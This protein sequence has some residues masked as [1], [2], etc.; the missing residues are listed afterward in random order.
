MSDVDR[1]DDFAG[2][3][4]TMY[5]PTVHDIGMQCD[6]DVVAPNNDDKGMMP[7][8]LENKRV[9]AVL[10][11]VVA[12]DVP[13]LHTDSGFDEEM[14]QQLEFQPGAARRVETDASKTAPTAT[15][16]HQVDPKSAGPVS[17]AAE[18]AVSSGACCEYT[19]KLSLSTPAT[20]AL[21]SD[22]ATSPE[23]ALTPAPLPYGH[24]NGDETTS[25]HSSN[26]TIQPVELETAAEHKRT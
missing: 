10:D 20:P 7:H 23:L 4:R 8:P 2:R 12:R 1:H 24:T 15:P 16:A 21:A 5:G 14:V 6:T 17:L 19:H 3:G 18:N 11:E 25:K 26:V 22:P 9:T 13:L